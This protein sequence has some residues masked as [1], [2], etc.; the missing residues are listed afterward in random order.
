MSTYQ[1][2]LDIRRN[3]GSGFFVLLDPDDATPEEL[4]QKA[5]AC[6]TADVDAILIG[7]SLVLRDSFS[8]AV[9]TV[10]RSCSLPVILFPGSPGQLS[11][12]AD[13]VLFLSLISGRNPQH[14]IVDHVVAAPSVK[15][16]GLEAIPTGYMLISSGSPTTVEFMSDTRPIPREKTDL[17][18]VHALA[19]QYLGLKLIYLEAG[20]GAQNSVPDAVITTVQKWVELPIIVGGGIKTSEDAAAKV[21]AGADFIVIG[22]ALEHETSTETVAKFSTEIHYAGRNRIN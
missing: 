18:A 15:R 1:K 13:A 5:V 17:V 11:S 6:Q 2:L 4:G 8:E 3:R 16:L 19:G 14:L 9:A 10:R 7:G 21:A 20:S 22:T 12:H